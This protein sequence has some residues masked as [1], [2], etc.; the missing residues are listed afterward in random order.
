M[1]SYGLYHYQP[2]FVT[3]FNKERNYSQF[4]INT[5]KIGFGNYANSGA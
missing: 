2:T 1:K 4:L 5:Y 3:T